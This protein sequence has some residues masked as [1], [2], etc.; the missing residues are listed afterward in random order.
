MESD[1][2]IC[3][4]I[5]PIKIH[6][7][8]VTQLH[9]LLEW[10][11]DALEAD[12]LRVDTLVIVLEA[13]DR[14]ILFDRLCG[15]HNHKTL[16]ALD[17]NLDIVQT[18]KIERVQSQNS[19]LFAT[20]ANSK[21]TL[22]PAL[23]ILVLDRIQTGQLGLHLAVSKTRLVQLDPIRNTIL[24]DILL[25]NIEQLILGLESPNLTCRIE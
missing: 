12:V 18:R 14:P 5:L 6:E 22:V 10:C 23:A 8:F 24:L 25:Q 2:R 20:L 13:D 19:H 17:I 9:K 4:V 3:D 11:R 7:V 1:S 16:G 21:T 15:T